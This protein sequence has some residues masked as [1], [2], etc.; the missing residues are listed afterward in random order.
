MSGFEESLRSISLNADATVGIY[1]GVPGQPGSAVP[2]GGKQYHF[3]KITGTKQVGLA[4]AAD[5]AAVVGVLQNKPQKPG[6]AATVGLSGVTNVVAG[7]AVS[8]G[9]RI[10]PDATGR[11]V[12]AGS[13][14]AIA[15]APA[16][17]A[18]EIIPAL[19]IK[20]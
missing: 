12:A 15:L 11:A 2:N 6:A 5:Q 19:L 7:A 4:L 3:L 10:G 13:G 20:A 9:A 1:T 17:G 14:P 8:A 18:G 16:A